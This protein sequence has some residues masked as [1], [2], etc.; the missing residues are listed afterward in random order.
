M[1]EQFRLHKVFKRHRIRLDL[2]PCPNG[3]TPFP[4]HLSFD[5]SKRLADIATKVNILLPLSFFH[6]LANFFPGSDSLVVYD[7]RVTSCSADFDKKKYECVEI[8]VKSGT[9]D[10]TDWLSLKDAN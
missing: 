2:Y 9:Y 1:A 3:E 4:L 5:G 10:R 8:V 7:I 6:V